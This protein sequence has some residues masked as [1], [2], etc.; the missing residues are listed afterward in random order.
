M[1]R[2]LLLMGIAMAAVPATADA[3]VVWLCE[4]GLTDNPCEIGQDTTIQHQEAQERA[5]P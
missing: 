5:Q 2:A 1:R 3:E 4:P